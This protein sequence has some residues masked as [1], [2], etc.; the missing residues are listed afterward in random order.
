[1]TPNSDE[2]FEAYLTMPRN[3]IKTAIDSLRESGFK[4]LKAW[5]LHQSERGVV[6]FELTD[7][8]RDMIF[9]L[10]GSHAWRTFALSYVAVPK[11]VP[12]TVIADF[13]QS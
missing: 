4:V 7:R 12:Q 6:C 2:V 5:E 11:T 3:L 1:M 13:E 9:R 10:I 8:R